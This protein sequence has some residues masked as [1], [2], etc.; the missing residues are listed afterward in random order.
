MV[1]A[2]LAT[3]ALQAQKLIDQ[4]RLDVLLVLDVHLEHQQQQF[5]ELEHIKTKSVKMFASLA[6][7]G[8]TASLTQ[9]TSH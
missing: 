5:V 2:L 9:L 3:T 4:L 1:P 7:Q 8:I 6:L